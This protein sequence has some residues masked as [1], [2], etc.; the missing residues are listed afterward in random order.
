MQE[1]NQ[2]SESSESDDKT[3]PSYWIGDFKNLPENVKHAIQLSK[4]RAKHSP[5]Y[6]RMKDLKFKIDVYK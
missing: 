1:D 6:F 5:F 4:V 3:Q 2:E